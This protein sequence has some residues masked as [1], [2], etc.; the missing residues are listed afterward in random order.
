M[1]IEQIKIGFDNYSYIIFCEQSKKA[2]IVDPGFG[3]TPVMNNIINKNLTIDH[4][5]ITHYHS[6]HTSGIKTIK[7]E[8]PR[9]S[10]VASKED[11]ESFEVDV[12]VSDGDTLSVGNVN[13]KFILTPGHTPGGICIIVDDKAII[14]GDTLFIGDCGRCDLPSGSISQM[15]ESLQI[16]K[17]LPDQLIVYPGHNYGNKP[18]DTL[19]NQKKTNKTLLAK[20]LEEFSKIS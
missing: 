14:T 11:G 2:A 18:F 10:L 19:G 1:T 13:L 17:E 16:I 5:L 6:D 20:S 3:V 15:F 12:F 8:F 7:K 9:A 4:I